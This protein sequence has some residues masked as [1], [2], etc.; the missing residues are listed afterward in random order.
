MELEITIKPHLIDRLRERW[1]ESNQEEENDL[2]RLV[3]QQVQNALRIRDYVKMP[4]GIY[5]PFSY[6]GKDGFVVVSDNGEATTVMPEEY[7]PE[8]TSVRRRKTA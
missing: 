8:A 5:V 3:R 1:P 7:C 6:L 2:H 4:G